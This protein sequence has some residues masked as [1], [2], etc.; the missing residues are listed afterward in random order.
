MDFPKTLAP[1]FHIN[2]P[3]RPMLARVA[4]SMFW[5][6]R[7]IERAEHIARLLLVHTNVLMDM[8]E[9]APKLEQR[10]W[11]GVLRVLNLD[12][13]PEAEAMFDDSI[14]E[15]EIAQRV[16]RY[17]TFSADNPNCLLECLTKARENARSIRENISAEMWQELNTMYWTFRADETR[18]RFEEEPQEMYRQVMNGS[19]LF[20][21][22]TNQ[23]LP[24]SQAWHFSQL[25]KHL[26]RGD[27]TCRILETK[28]EV[29]RAAEGALQT[30]P[31]RNIHW[32]AVLRS[33]CAIEAYR[34]VQ[35]GDLDPL[36]V[37]AFLILENE[38][39]RSV[40]YSVRHSHE[41]V[42]GI[43][44]GV[45]SPE[46]DEA[47]RVLGRLRAELENADPGEIVYDGVQAYLQKVRE[48][49]AVAGM[50][51]QRAYFLH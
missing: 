50:A 35:P 42:C 20:Q 22:L 14:P 38:L 6:S 18:T 15:S 46:V 3:A 2:R 30:T 16:G 45:G 23:T 26:E 41:A 21:G 10:L 49:I 7:Y 39:P 1:K 9:L 37:A 32:M 48:K 51:V 25:A 8:G 5:M 44:R 19:F 28:F 36:H 17:M 47:E 31:I 12:K 11:L 34:R 29:L 13:T 24:H 40:C 4:E 33:C 43:R 27:I